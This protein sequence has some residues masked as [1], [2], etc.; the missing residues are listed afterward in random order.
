MQPTLN[1]L[2][3]FGYFEI[4]VGDISN[5]IFFL[6]PFLHD[7]VIYFETITGILQE[8]RPESSSFSK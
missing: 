6:I 2:V 1:L 8:Y 7:T 4:G 3:V 5:I